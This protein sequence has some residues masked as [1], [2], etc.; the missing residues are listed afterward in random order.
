MGPDLTLARATAATLF[1][2]DVTVR[3]DPEGDENAQ[4]DPVTL[5]LTKPAAPVVWTGKIMLRP[6]RRLPANERAGGQTLTADDYHG[7]FPADAPTIPLGAVLTVDACPRAQMVGRQ[8][9][10]TKIEDGSMGVTQIVRLLDQP[11]GPD[12]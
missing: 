7:R 9:V 10:V 8:L 4:R 5:T 6:E 1:D 2:T 11:R 3:F 12:T